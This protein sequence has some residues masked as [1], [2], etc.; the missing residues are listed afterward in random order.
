MIP[1]ELMVENV[2]HLRMMCSMSLKK[3][4]K[5]VQVE[6]KR[7]RGR[8]KTPCATDQQYL[9]VTSLKPHYKWSPCL[10]VSGSNIH[11]CV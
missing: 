2:A 1:K 3:N 9:E 4:E 7:R 10:S 11:Q 6:D 5:T 8:P